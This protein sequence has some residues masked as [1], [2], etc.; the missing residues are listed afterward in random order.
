MWIKTFPKI[1]SNW[2]SLLSLCKKRKW[3][4]N[5]FLGVCWRLYSCQSEEAAVWRLPPLSCSLTSR[6]SLKEPGGRRRDAL[7]QWI[8]HLSH[9]EREGARTLWQMRKYYRVLLNEPTFKCML[10]LHMSYQQT[11]HLCTIC[12]RLNSIYSWSWSPKLQLLLQ[13]FCTFSHVFENK[14]TNKATFF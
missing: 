13:R 7:L 10:S 5:Q 2:E 4:S 12:F 1:T 3:R 14:S 6:T 11:V 8:S 9:V